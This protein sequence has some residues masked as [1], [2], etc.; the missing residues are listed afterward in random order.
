MDNFTFSKAESQDNGIP[1]VVQYK[2]KE[3]NKWHSKNL[4]LKKEYIR[5]INQDG[6]YLTDPSE[7]VNLIHANIPFFV[8]RTVDTEFY[9]GKD[10]PLFTDIPFD[11]MYYTSQ[12][13]KG[14]SYLLQMDKNMFHKSN[15]DRERYRIC[16]QKQRS[17]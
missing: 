6:K 11:P 10:Y 14:Y 9:L 2:T 16:L 8:N 1:F 17:T 7:I 4:L 13:L 5:T 3:L 15:F 12:V